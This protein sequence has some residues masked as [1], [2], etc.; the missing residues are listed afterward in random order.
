MRS[1][2]LSLLTA[3][4]ALLLSLSTPAPAAAQA[5]APEV[6]ALQLDADAA[7]DPGSQLQLRV[8]GS[9]RGR[10]S[11]QVAG[12]D[13]VVPL[14]ETAPG[15]YRGSHTVS[16]RDA[17]DPTRTLRAS[18]ALGGM[19]TSRNFS[20]PPAFV[21]LARPAGAQAQTQARMQT[22]AQAQP[23]RIDRF[24]VR[25]DGPLSPGAQVRFVLEGA[26][27]GDASVNLP[28]IASRLPLREVRPGQYRGAYTLRRNDNTAALAS[29]AATLRLSGQWVTANLT[30]PL[31]PTQV[32]GAASGPVTLEVLS[33]A[34]H[35]TVDTALVQVRGRTAPHATV[36]ARV[37]AVPP[38]IGQR[39]GV[40]QRLFE[41]NVTAN[42]SGDFSF[43]FDPR[44]LALPGTRYEVQLSAGSGAQA[45]QA[46]L[47]LLQ[48][49]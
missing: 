15:V 18:I 38:L 5:R 35:S 40:A 10:A 28:G 7:L 32:L 4:M 43:S 1:A 36:R 22:P 34:N 14:R 27:G 41:D 31:A 48:R 12:T 46:R 37:E 2:S 49:G 29:A 6:N 30:E 8:E 16:R 23:P 24:E 11:V 19:T 33:P 21:A 47:V 20:F 26:S 17:I 13:I 45:S 9:P 44:A 42:A 25:P 39:L 3:F